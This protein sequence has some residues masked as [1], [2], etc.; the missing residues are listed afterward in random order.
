MNI[1]KKLVRSKF[2]NLSVKYLL[3]NK[4][5]M[6][7]FHRPVQRGSVNL[8]YWKISAEKD[9]VGDY[10]SPVVVGWMKQERGIVSDTSRD[11]KTRHLVA[12]G[13]ILDMSYQDAVVWGSGLQ[14]DKQYWWRALR[15][16]DIRCVRGP[17]T[18]RVLQDNGYDCPEIYGDPAVL[19]PLF[20][21]PEK[22]E[23]EFDYRVIHHH[24]MSN[25]DPSA[26]DPVTDDWKGFI[27][28]LVKS[29]RI[30]SSSLHGVILAEAYGVPAVLL[31]NNPGM[32][33]YRDYYYSTG[34]YSFPVAKS[35]EEA[36][37]IEPA[38]L[39][40]LRPLQKNLLNSFPD[41]LWKK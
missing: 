27:D 24:S 6:N 26:L 30:I 41:D 2:L 8:H 5:I 13:S 14:E 40:D 17:E 4:L 10:L 16:L 9:N 32:F 37:S 15:K 35:V 19:L 36:L 25:P 23:K 38:Q 20:Y 11:G 3:R 34:R 7:D 1:I 33:K 18:R 22:Q 28:A 12:I 31:A 21:Q 39:P 29:R